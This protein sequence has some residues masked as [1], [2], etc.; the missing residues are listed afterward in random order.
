MTS[1]VLKVIVKA[2]LSNIPVISAKTP[3]SSLMQ[4]P[5]HLGVNK[6]QKLVE[7]KK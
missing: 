2:K 6:R 7:L 3:P 5:T 1:I 4:S